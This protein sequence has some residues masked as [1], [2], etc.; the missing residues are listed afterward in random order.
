VSRE[1]EGFGEGKGGAPLKERKQ[2]CGGALVG[3]KGAQA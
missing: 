2:A 1:E 3:S